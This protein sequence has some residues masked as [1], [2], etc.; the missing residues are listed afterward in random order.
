LLRRRIELCKDDDLRTMEERL[1]IY[2]NL[3]KPENYLWVGFSASDLEGKEIRP[4]IVFDKLRKLFP[5][6]PVEKDICNL[7]DPMALIERPMSTLKHMTEGLRKAGAGE[8][9]LA[10]PWKA[11][12]NWYHDR[13]DRGLSMVAQGI[14]FT[15]HLERLEANLVKKLFQRKNVLDLTLSPSR[16][17]KFARCPFA[18]LVLYGLAPEER[19]VFEVAGR[20][21][22]DVYHECL[23]RL[24]K[25]LTIKGM[26]ITDI[27]SPWMTL[28]KAQ[29]T[30]KVETLM[31]E[32]AEEY[33]D[34]M[35]ISGQE[36]R[37]RASRMKEVCCKAAWALVEHIQQGRIKEVFFEEAFGVGD[38]KAFPPIR[39][40][41]GDQVLSIEGK[42]DRVDVLPGGYVKVIDYKSGKEHFDSN[43]AKGGWRLQLMLYLKAA[44]QGMEARNQAAKPAGVFYFEIADPQIDATA[45][46]A[47]V[48]QKKLETEVRRAFKLDGIVLDDPNVIDGIAGEFSGYSEILPLHKNKDGGVSGTADSKLL[49]EEE[50]DALR[51]AVDQTIEEL[52]ASLASGVIDIH[53]KKTKHETACKYCEYKSICNFELSFDGCSYDVVK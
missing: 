19:R 28:D 30:Q 51:T 38:E 11:A 22:G 32:I 43:E 13:E 1:A 10:A 5:D 46:N 34:G 12:Y 21:A 42:I 27:N 37:Y 50:F 6:V 45:L 8:G 26:E 31:E 53:P 44:M 24:S 23:M 29:C 33:K 18:H 20:E 14:A 17:E 48:L 47:E 40:E 36:E 7:E 3:S 16:L 15:N 9:E 2:K 52:C 41:V 4:S 39:I 25:S 49:N 35:L